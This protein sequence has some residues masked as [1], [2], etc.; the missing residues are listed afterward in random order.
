[1]GLQADWIEPG[2]MSGREELSWA[3]DGV[4]EMH[5]GAVTLRRF[6]PEAMRL[7]ILW[8][9]YVFN[10]EAEKAAFDDHTDDLTLDIILD[11]FA[12]DLRARGVD[13][14]RSADALQD[15]ALRNLLL[16]TYQPAAERYFPEA[17]REPVPLSAET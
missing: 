5:E 17:R 6:A 2:V 14:P 12:D 11:V 9:A 13:M 4:W 7:S 1:V 10:D 16:T 8:K 15:R 3:A